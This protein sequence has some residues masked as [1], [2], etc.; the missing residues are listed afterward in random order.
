MTKS[1]KELLQELIDLEDKNVEDVESDYAVKNE[2]Q[3]EKNETIN[4]KEINVSVE[5]PKK[6]RTEKQLEAFERAKKIRDAN[7]V[8][9]KEERLKREEEERKQIEEKLIKKAIALKKKQIKKQVLLDEISDDDTPIQK[10][11]KVVEKQEQVTSGAFEPEKPKAER[12]V[13]LGPIIRFV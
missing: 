13:P 7:A 9:R 4:D 2:K 11:K 6:P 8:K 3:D 12:P 10:I 1:K 5:K